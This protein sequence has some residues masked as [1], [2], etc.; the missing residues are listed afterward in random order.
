ML[1]VQ[2]QVVQQLR[3]LLEGLLLLVLQVCA[4]LWQ[5]YSLSGRIVG[6]AYRQAPVNTGSVCGVC[7][8]GM[9]R[10]RGHTNVG[11]KASQEESQANTSMR[12]VGRP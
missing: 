11:C 7:V 8:E 10:G 5:K 6:K 2:Q 12:Q 9:G 4:C 1:A 3:V